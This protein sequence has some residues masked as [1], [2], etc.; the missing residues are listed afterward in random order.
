VL[1]AHHLLAYFEM[2][3]RDTM[4]FGGCYGFADEMP[5]GSGALAGVPYPIDREWVAKELEFGR[6]SRNSI[7][8]VSDRDFVIDFQQAAAMTMM[9]IS[10]LA[11][12]IILW[13]SSEFGFVR[14]PAAFATGSSIMP[15]KRTPDIAEL[16]AGVQDMQGSSA[17]GDSEGLPRCLATSETKRRSSRQRT[18]SS[19]S[20][21]LRG[22]A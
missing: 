6:I 12:E 15:Q 2:L 1:L 21:R 17:P 9:H 19:H 3:D 8:A 14:L 7:D 11:E 4:R 18:R 20:R 5:L 22:D 10:R 13:S 16:R